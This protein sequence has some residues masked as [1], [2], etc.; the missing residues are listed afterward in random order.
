MVAHIMKLVKL[1]VIW[2]E[3]FAILVD[4]TYTKNGGPFSSNLFYCKEHN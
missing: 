2:V 4:Q 3:G 1:V